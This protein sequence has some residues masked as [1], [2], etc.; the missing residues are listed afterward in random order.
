MEGGESEGGGGREGRGRGGGAFGLFRTVYNG[1]GGSGGR[2]EV[3]K[4]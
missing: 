2:F 1:K 3:G 4:C